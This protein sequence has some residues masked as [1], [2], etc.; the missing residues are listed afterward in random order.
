MTHM[1]CF[2]DWADFVYTQMFLLQQQAASAATKLEVFNFGT[3]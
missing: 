1:Q 2:G 3:S